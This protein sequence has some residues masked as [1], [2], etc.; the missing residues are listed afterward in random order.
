MPTDTAKK[1]V[2]KCSIEVRNLPLEAFR[3]PTD[4]RKWKQSARSRCALLGR[5]ATYANPDGTFTRNGINYSPS[6]LTLLKHVSQKSYYRLA[7]DLQRL[8]LLSW[9]REKHHERR[10]YTI[11][12]PEQVLDSSQNPSGTGVILEVEQPEQVSDSPE[13]VSPRHRTGVT[14]GEH[15]SFPSLP[16]KERAEKAVA[17][18]AP[19]RSWSKANP[20]DK[21]RALL[22][23]EDIK[24]VALKLTEGA[25]TFYPKASRAMAKTILEK[26]LDRE[27]VLLAVRERVLD[28]AGDSFRLQHCGSELAEMLGPIVEYK[29][30]AK[31]AKES[32]ERNVAASIEAGIASRRAAS[33]TASARI[34]AEEELA[35]KLGDS[36][37]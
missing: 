4:G 28:I 33:D 13:Q 19:A 35:A 24:R 10:E 2:T 26:N 32:E 5:L 36:P 20:A 30:E 12:L 34:R 6:L 37:F 11:H 8:G 1:E 9:T 7:D 17:Q 25:A 16:S 15:P 3:L 21:E 27:S 23:V 22:L 14:M 18:A 31:E 29:I